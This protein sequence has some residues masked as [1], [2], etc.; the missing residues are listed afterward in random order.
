VTSFATFGAAVAG[1]YVSWT[2]TETVTLSGTRSGS[3]IAVT[4]IVASKMNLQ[5]AE[6]LFGGITLSEQD[7]VWV[8]PDVLLQSNGVQ[9]GDTIT[10]SSS[11]VW[12][13]GQYVKRVKFDTQW[14]FNSV[15]QV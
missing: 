4:G 7:K 15:Q 1:E 2:N 12:T 9:Q 3:P 5:K 8:L 6:K 10:D 11:V 13:V 14:V